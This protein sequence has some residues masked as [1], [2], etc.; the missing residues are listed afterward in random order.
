MT[1][2]DKFLGKYEIK[3]DDTF[4]II[5]NSVSTNKETG[6]KTPKQTVIGYYSTLGGALSKC[7]LMLTQES[8]QD[9]A[10]ISEIVEKFQ[11]LWLDIKNTIKI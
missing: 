10:T 7:C 3:C 6:E 4:T 9:T 5:E 2:K 1:I 8:F 11:S